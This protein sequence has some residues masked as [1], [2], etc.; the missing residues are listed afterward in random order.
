M[1]WFETLLDVGSFA[2]SYKSVNQLEELVR[3]GKNIDVDVL[4]EVKNLVF[5]FK[6]QFKSILENKDQNLKKT[7][8]ILSFL[9]DRYQRLKISPD[10]FPDF[11]DKE[12]VLETSNFIN[13]STQIALNKL[14]KNELESILKANGLFVQFIELDYYIK[15][16]S[17]ISKY[18][19]AIDFLENKKSNFFD[20]KELK[21]AEREVVL[22]KDVIDLDIAT[23]I[24]SLCNSNLSTAVTL[25]NDLEKDLIEMIGEIPD[26]SKIDQIDAVNSKKTST[27]IITRNSQALGALGKF[28]VY[29]DGKEIGSFSNGETQEFITSCGAHEFGFPVMGLVGWSNKM[30]KKTSIKINCES[31]QETHLFFHYV[32][33]GGKWDL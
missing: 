10:I 22:Q 3:Q 12:Y 9:K 15:N 27:V 6:S 26:L 11:S 19:V 13:N 5:N 2:L 21:D 31:D 29:M 32:V 8:L 20:K 18:L 7:A 17:N 14:E 30:N 24:N 28:P 23:R 25:K 16:Y 33:N 4:K 1:D